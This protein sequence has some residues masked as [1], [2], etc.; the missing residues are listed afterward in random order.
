MSIKNLFGAAGTIRPQTMPTDVSEQ[1]D[2]LKSVVA[3]QG[4]SFAGEHTIKASIGLESFDQTA[5]ADLETSVQNLQAVIS[6]VV[7]K[8]KSEL[9]VAQESAAVAAGIMACSAPHDL[10]GSVRS[11]T[12]LKASEP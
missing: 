8:T 11:G 10:R 7:G 5:K 4:N 3:A 12:S 1:L 2:A 6:R 9:T